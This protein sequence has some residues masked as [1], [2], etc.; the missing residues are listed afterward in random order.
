MKKE[1]YSLILA[2]ILKRIGM[3]K[4]YLLG[5]LKEVTVRGIMLT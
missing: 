3:L 1:E 2:I 5:I 4:F